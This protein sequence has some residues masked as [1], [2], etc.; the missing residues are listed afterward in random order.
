MP[1]NELDTR[2][3]AAHARGDRSAL[4]ALYTEAANGTDSD[5]AKG[6]Y[7][8][9]AYVFALEAGD[10]RITELRQTLVEMG[11]EVQS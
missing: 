11:R 10:S 8:T 3:L 5:E 1:P 9:H 7:L 4:I 2:L 6:F